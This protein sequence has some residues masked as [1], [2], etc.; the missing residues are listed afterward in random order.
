M[1]IACLDISFNV[2]VLIT[3]T[4]TSILQGKESTGLSLSSINQDP[5][6]VWSADHWFSFTVK[7]DEWLYVLHAIMFF[8]VFGTTPEMR[9]YYRSAFWFISERCGYKRKRVSEVETVSDVAFNSNPGE[10]A[11]NP[12]A[13]NRRRG[14][15]SF[16][17]TTI[18]TSAS[19]SAGLG[20]AS[21]LGAATTHYAVEEVTSVEGVENQAAHGA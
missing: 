20:E 4:T 3:L 2:P 21:D 19:R 12:P 13:G 10:Q 11:G 6:T 7:W 8:S 16:L 17:E 14:S 9:Q 15:L 5:A 18:D 1:A